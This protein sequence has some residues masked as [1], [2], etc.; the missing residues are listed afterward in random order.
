MQ[1]TKRKTCMMVVGEAEKYSENDSN[2]G[3]EISD[4]NVSYS[5]DVF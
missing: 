4:A 2:N 1:W 5:E 3:R